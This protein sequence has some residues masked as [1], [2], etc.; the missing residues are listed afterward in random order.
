MSDRSNVVDGLLASF[1]SDW[2][3]Q[4]RASLVNKNIHFSFHLGSHLCIV[5]WDVFGSVG[6][7]ESA[8]RQCCCLMSAQFVVKYLN[9]PFILRPILFETPIE[10]TGCDLG[11]SIVLVY[12]HC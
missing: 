1:M 12:S 11:G 3:I 5:M 6:I 10:T 7:P 4:D 9:E 8:K 2:E